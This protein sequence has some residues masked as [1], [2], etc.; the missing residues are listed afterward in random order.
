MQALIDICLKVSKAVG[1][2]QVSAKSAVNA[3]G[4]ARA[5]GGAQR[6]KPFDAMNSIVANLLLNLTGCVVV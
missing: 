6:E 3:A 2:G 5:G 1:T 4:K